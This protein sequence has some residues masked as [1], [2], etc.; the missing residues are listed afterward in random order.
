M[1]IND[2]ELKRRYDLLESTNLL[3]SIELVETRPR[4]LKG[5]TEAK[6][7]TIGDLLQYDQQHSRGIPSVSPKAQREII[8]RIKERFGAPIDTVDPRDIYPIWE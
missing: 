2:S 1:T 7:F 3:A 6:I 8:D 4:R 5:F